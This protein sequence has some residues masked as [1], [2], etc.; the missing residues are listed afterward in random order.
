MFRDNHRSPTTGADAPALPGRTHGDS[1]TLIAAAAVLVVGTL[2]AL[3]A[4]AW[5]LTNF[6][7]I[8]DSQPLP[9][10]MGTLSIDTGS[11]S[12]VAPAR[13]PS[14]CRPTWRAG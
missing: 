14:C 2:V 9:S 12:G 7:I 5:G 11:V 6:R 4:V 3:S 13:S 8:T 1:A 10:A